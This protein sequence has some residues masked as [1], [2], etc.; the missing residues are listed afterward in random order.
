[1]LRIVLPVA[2]ALRV[3][4]IPVAALDVVAIAPID[5][6]VAVKVVVIVD[7]DVIVAAPSG[8]PAPTAAPGCSDRETDTKGNRHA[9]RVITR[10]RIVDGWIGI[11]RSSVHHSGVV[12]RNINNVGTG[13]LDHDDLLVL[14]NF[15][16]DLLL[17]AGLQVALL[18]RL[19]AH[20]LDS[21]HHVTLLGEEGVA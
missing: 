11:G 15:G 5:I 1:M 20:A 16:F 17:F 3:H 18:I 9:R 6:G 14:Y 10:W 2:A 4:L 12:A 8:S 21:I 13:R 7:V 19:L